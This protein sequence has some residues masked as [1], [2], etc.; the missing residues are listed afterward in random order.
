MAIV[1]SYPIAQIEPSD[2]LIGTKTVEVGEPTKSFLVSD[3][4]NLTI[5]TLG[6]TGASGYFETADSKVVTVVNGL[7]TDIEIIA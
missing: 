7:I 3:L 5:S 6:S 4:I 1:Y 2:L